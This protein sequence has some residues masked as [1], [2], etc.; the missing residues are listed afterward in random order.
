MAALD[1]VV[2]DLEVGHRLGPSVVSELQISVGLKCVGAAGV[3][4]YPGQPGV[5]AARTTSDHALVEKI[6]TRVGGDMVLVA[7][8]IERLLTVTEVERLQV[9]VSAPAD[10]AG[11]GAGPGI[12]TAQPC[13]GRGERGVTTHTRHLARDLPS[14]FGKLLDVE[15]AETGTVGHIKLGDRAHQ[16]IAR[17]IG[18]VA[19]E[20]RCTRTF[21]KAND[22]TGKYRRPLARRVIADDDRAID[23]NPP[24]HVNQ[25]GIG[26]ERIVET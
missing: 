6:G 20:H 26:C 18:S 21:I 10:E 25:H 15:I 3:G 1:V 2:L 17:G 23:R 5:D 22:Q 19:V 12:G 24:G 9:G 14:R 7:A 11:V 8:K 4:A 13:C 16:E